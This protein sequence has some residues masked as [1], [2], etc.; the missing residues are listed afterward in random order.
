MFGAS[1]KNASCF[2]SG[3]RA[4]AWIRSDG[5]EARPLCG[6]ASTMDLDIGDRCRALG[7]AALCNQAGYPFGK[8][9]SYERCFN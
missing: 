5:T 2:E 4:R 8:L 1:L 3:V 6:I 9:L 7:A